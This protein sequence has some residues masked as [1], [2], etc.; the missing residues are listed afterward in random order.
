MTAQP[1]A[2]SRPKLPPGP[3]GKLLL[4]NSLDFI[5]DPLGFLERARR[6]HGD[7]VRLRLGPHRT[8]LVSHPEPVESIL[9]NHADDCAPRRCERTTSG[10][11]LNTMLRER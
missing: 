7:V 8:Y 9:R 1:S 6:D 5:R 2:P 3:R 10:V 4:G 11:S